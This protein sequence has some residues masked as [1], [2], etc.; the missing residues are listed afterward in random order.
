MKFIIYTFF[1]ITVL[2]CKSNSQI[3]QESSNIADSFHIRLNEYKIDRCLT[4]ILVAVV[5]ADTGHVRFPPNLYC[6]NLLFS[7]YI[8]YRDLIIT[9]SRWM[10]SLP[11][12]C[13]GLIHINDMYF[14]CCGNF[15]KDSLFTNTGNTLDLKIN[16]SK[17]EKYDLLDSKSYW[18]DWY[19][20]KSSS[21]A[22]IGELNL[23]H[24]PP[25][26]LH[27]NVGKKLSIFAESPTL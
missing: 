3:E 17:S 26:S 21:T 7:N 1:L 20:K 11:R 6:Y 25:I 22:I 14:L 9:P 8:N 5:E 23:C 18:T 2:A 27:L 10:E 24:G 12:D 19:S 15:N 16:H 13:T 4:D